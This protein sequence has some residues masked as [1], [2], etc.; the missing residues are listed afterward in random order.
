MR[1]AVTTAFLLTLVLLPREAAAWVYPEH[2]DIA[3]LS[4]ENLDAD[5]RAEFDALWAAGRAGYEGRLCETAAD[6]TQGVTPECIDW[7]AFPAIAGDHSCSSRNM[8]EIVTGT[9]WILEVADISAQL[10]QD[11][12]QI[13]VEAPPDQEEEAEGPVADIQR[14]MASEAVRAERIN[15]LRTAD[16]RLQ[17]ADPEYATR[18]GSNNAHFLLA[19][20]EVDTGARE[21][22]VATMAPDAEINALGVY[23]WYHMRALEKAAKLR[24]ASLPAATRQKLAISALADEAF[25][26]HFLEDMYAAGHVAGTWGDAS[27]RKGTHDYYNEAG[28][29]A[30]TWKP[31]SPPV[32]LMGDAHMRPQ[33]AVFASRSISASLAQLLDVAAGRAEPFTTPWP[34]DVSLEPDSFDVCLE[35]TMPEPPEGHLLARDGRSGHFD[36]T[37]VPT[38]VPGLG[39]G[40]GAL[41]RFRA[42]VGPFIGLAAGIDARGLSGGFAS[43][44]DGGAMSGIDLACRF[45]L[46]L[47]GVVG[48]SG[49]GL[50]Y[51]QIGFRADTPS[52]G[53]IG[54]SDV[55]DEAGNITS[56]IPS[57]VGLATRFRMPFYLIP[58]DLLF[59]SPIY[60]FSPPT[61]TKIAVTAGNGGLIPWQ[62]GL[63]T[64]IGRFQLVLGREV[65]ADFYGVLGDEDRIAVPGDG[66]VRNPG[67]I[68]DYDSIRLDFPI[69][70]YRPYR[71]FSSNQSS[72]LF[73]QFFAGVDIPT[74]SEVVLPKR[75]LSIDLDPV[76]S[77]GLRFTYDWRYYF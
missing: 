18:A 21:Y 9:Q 70:E 34:D 27:Q 54:D 3:I 56:T 72:A 48:E 49:D 40:L 19:R 25:A 23:V 5:R 42:E 38:A 16:T 45:G 12:A 62:A 39:P 65:A 44:Q 14:R 76:Y 43:G 47:D 30:F 58:G 74:R 15:V 64:G 61:Y 75:P 8:F 73:F 37:L 4:V 11:L 28:L 1:A 2:R 77:I 17:R 6:T 55:I 66:S 32:V 33:D 67:K 68:V 59:L 51:A 71:A 7:A 46:G 52:S 41:P 60:F 10:K 20:P 36:D 69:L 29:E 22:A 13:E 57:R 50:V 63:A 24:D 31:D 35:M 53:R 26:L